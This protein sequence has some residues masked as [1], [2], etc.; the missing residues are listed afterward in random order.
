MS[1]ATARRAIDWKILIT[2][3]AALGVSTAMEKSG[4]AEAIAGSLL[5]A[6]KG[7]GDA[8]LIGI[9]YIVTMLA[10]VRRVAG[11]SIYLMAFAIMIAASAVY[12]TP[13]GDNINLMTSGV[14]DYSVFE[15]VRFGLPL[16]ILMCITTTAILTVRQRALMA[17]ITGIAT[18]AVVVI[19][20]LLAGFQWWRGYKAR[21]ARMEA[22]V[23]RRASFAR[24]SS[25]NAGRLSAARLGSA[26]GA[27]GSSHAVGSQGA[28]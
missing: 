14:G 27:Q 26:A 24:A 13:F 8:A 17:T 6:A 16:Q 4:A 3:G 18:A 10:R 7:G 23:E 25:M 11:I 2:I 20:H 15:F 5:N 28:V 1:P 19:P 21:K 9:I 22:K 12:T